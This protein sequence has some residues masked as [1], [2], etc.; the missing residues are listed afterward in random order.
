MEQPFTV[1]ALQVVKGV[2]RSS[3]FAIPGRVHHGSKYV[4]CRA[5]V[6]R[7][8]AP[9]EWPAEALRSTA[10]FARETSSHTASVS[11]AEHCGDP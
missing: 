10:T 9:E 11:A 2:H 3:S 7:P 8:Q 4:I 1:A 5:Q 6:G